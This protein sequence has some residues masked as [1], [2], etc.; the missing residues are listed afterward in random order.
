MVYDYRQEE[1]ADW[2]TSCGW[3]YGFS[4]FERKSKI[5]GKFDIKKHGCD[6]CSEVDKPIDMPDSDDERTADLS[7][8]S[9]QPEPLSENIGV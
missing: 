1:R 8:S 7:G 3:A 6:R 9:G 4:I 5:P 2:K